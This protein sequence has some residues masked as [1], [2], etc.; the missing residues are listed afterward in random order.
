VTIELKIEF[1]ES[2][3]VISGSLKSEE[4]GPLESEKSGLYRF[5][6]GT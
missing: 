1:L 5:I 4:I 3:K 2:E 6:L